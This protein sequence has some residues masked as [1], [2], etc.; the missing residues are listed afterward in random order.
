M[1]V[2][3]STEGAGLKNISA[4]FFRANKIATCGHG[5]MVHPTRAI[6]Y[7]SF[8][9]LAKLK[10]EEIHVFFVLMIWNAQQGHCYTLLWW[11]DHK[12]Q[13][14]TLFPINVMQCRQ[15]GKKSGSFVPCI[16]HENMYYSSDR[17]WL[18]CSFA[19]GI[20]PAVSECKM[21]PWGPEKV[22]LPIKA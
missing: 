22:L 8:A 6:W 5:T 20:P 12:L 2:F 19:A 11:N 18:P 4:K 14:Q 3:T 7:I 21:G 13:S 15:T 17:L 16:S 9:N 10:D 1:C